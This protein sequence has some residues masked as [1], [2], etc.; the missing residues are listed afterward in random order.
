MQ[1]NKTIQTA[2]T[3]NCSQTNN[4]ISQQNKTKQIATKQQQTKNN[5]LELVQNR[6]I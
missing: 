5:R 1:L 4:N 3:N 2:E 6:I